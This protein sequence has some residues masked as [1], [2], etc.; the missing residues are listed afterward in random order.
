MP[1]STSTMSL[2]YNRDLFDRFGVAYP[3]DGMTWDEV[4]EL[5]RVMTRNEGGIQ[6][7]GLTMAFQHAMFLNQNSANF[8]ELNTNKALLDSEEFK[9]TLSNYAMFFQIPG[10][11]M[12]N[13]RYSLGS[14]QKPF[15]TDHTAAMFLTLNSPIKDDPASPNWDVVQAPSM[16]DK[17]GVGMQSYPNYAYL[18]NMSKNKQAAFHVLA[19]LTSLEYQQ[20]MVEN[21]YGFSALKDTKLV[22]KYGMNTPHLQTRNLK[23]LMAQTFAPPTVKGVYQTMGDKEGYQALGD[24]LDGTDINTALRNANERLDKAIAAEEGK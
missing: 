23:G 20:W 3:K 2:F 10:N 15:L 13:N 12:P 4:Y 1:V 16:S 19:Y 5:A 24:Y 9:K 17:P 8:V 7:K 11:E 18:T 22:E 6:Y 14:Q 21:G